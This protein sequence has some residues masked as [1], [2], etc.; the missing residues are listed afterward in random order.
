MFWHRPLLVFHSPSFPGCHADIKWAV[1]RLDRGGEAVLALL[2][3]EDVFNSHLSSFL[4]VSRLTLPFICSG[5]LLRP[6]RWIR[7][8]RQ[9]WLEN[10]QSPYR[11]AAL[12]KR[13]QRQRWPAACWAFF[14][15]IS[16]LRQ[17]G[18][19]G[20]REEGWRG[21]VAWK[22]VCYEAILAAEPRAAHTHTHIHS[23]R[24]SG[25]AWRMWR[26]WSVNSV[27][28]YLNVRIDLHSGAASSS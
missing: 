25:P 7:A 20:W 1:H 3:F 2:A 16:G 27:M 28:N 12:D 24:S 18:Q 15:M 8:T 21:N 13:S 23:N 9:R 11:S 22:I 10:I 5:V 19:R 6:D 4:S 26:A 14:L 17:D